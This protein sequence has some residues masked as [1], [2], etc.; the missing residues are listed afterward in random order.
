MDHPDLLPIAQAILEHHAEVAAIDSAGVPMEDRPVVQR[1]PKT[2]A[3][4]LTEAGRLRAQIAQTIP[5]P[6]SRLAMRASASLA[7][8]RPAPRR[9]PIGF[10]VTAA[11]PVLAG[12][13]G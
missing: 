13:R 12:R 7:D 4:G 1:L 11:G 3:A 2:A 5:R 10:A 6:G 9:R 8:A